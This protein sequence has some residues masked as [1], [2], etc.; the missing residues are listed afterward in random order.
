MLNIYQ[1]EQR[2]GRIKMSTDRNCLPPDAI[3]TETRIF[4]DGTDLMNAVK[5][6]EK[7]GFSV[8]VETEHMSYETSAGKTI[9]RNDVRFSEDFGMPYY[10]PN[11][12]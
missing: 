9:R 6:L 4:V 8:C 12:A 5:A 1:S 3:R 7:R 2:G 10:G 11:D